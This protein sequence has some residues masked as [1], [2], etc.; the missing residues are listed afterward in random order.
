MRYGSIEFQVFLPGVQKTIGGCFA[1]QKTQGL[2]PKASSGQLGLPQ[3]AENRCFASVRSPRIL[4]RL[5]RECVGLVA[6]LLG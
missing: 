4:A 6:D 1:L 5:G 3:I 2:T